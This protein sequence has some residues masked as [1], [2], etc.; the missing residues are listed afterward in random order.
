M[1]LSMRGCDSLV[2]KKRLVIDLADTVHQGLVPDARKL[3]RIIRKPRNPRLR[4][5]LGSAHIVAMQVGEFSQ[6]FLRETALYPQ[7]Y[8][9][10]RLPSSHT[11][12]TNASISSLDEPPECNSGNRKS[13]ANSLD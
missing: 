10:T 11:V 7:T 8:S 1:Y 6:A 12:S 9:I 3:A 5:T 2:G 4:S 13:G